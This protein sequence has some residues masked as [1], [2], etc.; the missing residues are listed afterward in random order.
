M[1]PRNHLN[2]NLKAVTEV[3]CKYFSTELCGI[4]VFF[5]VQALIR[6]QDSPDH[7]PSMDYCGDFMKWRFS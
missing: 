3:N 2:I 1:G 6:R 5:V 4:F 7:T